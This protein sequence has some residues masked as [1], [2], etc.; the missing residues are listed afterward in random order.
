[1]KRNG[2]FSTSITVQNEIMQQSRIRIIYIRSKLLRFVEEEE[3]RSQS[4]LKK[5]RHVLFLCF[6]LF[7]NF[8]FILVEF[9]F[10][11]CRRRDSNNNTIRGDEA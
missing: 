11:F 9:F 8:S 5:K 6:V 3:N 2:A 4:P 7:R 1:M 10:R